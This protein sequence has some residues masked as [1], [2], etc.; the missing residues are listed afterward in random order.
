MATSINSNKV[1][2]LTF[3][4]TRVAKIY[5][6]AAQVAQAAYFGQFDVTEFDGE[7]TEVHENM[8]V[9]SI[10]TPKELFKEICIA[11]RPIIEE[12]FRQNVVRNL[13]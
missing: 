2:D 8:G 12:E 7:N 6:K 11:I 4:E 10:A 13:K 1:A 9:N 3:Q 5:A